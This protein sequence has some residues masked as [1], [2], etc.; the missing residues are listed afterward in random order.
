MKQENSTPPPLQILLLQ[1]Q[2]ELRD[3]I[4]FCIESAYGAVVQEASSYAQ[5]IQFLK[6]AAIPFDIVVLDRKEE[7]IELQNQFWELVG[8]LPVLLAQKVT[9][10][11][12][13]TPNRVIRL[14]DRKKIVESLTRAIDELVNKGMVRSVIVVSDYCRIR[15]RLLLSIGSLRG[16][17]YLRLS[18]DKF[19]KLFSSGANF[20]KDDYEKY[21]V[22]KGIP[23]LYI[24]KEQCQEFTEQY[25]AQ[26]GKLLTA[27]S[28]NLHKISSLNKFT[29]EIVQELIQQ[30][31]FTKAV[32]N[33][34]RTQ[35]LLTVKALGGHPKLSQIMKEIHRG[36]GKYI[37]SHST[38]CAYFACSLA[39]ELHWTT[40]S[41]FQKLTLASFLHDITLS[42]HALAA[43]DSLSELDAKKDQFTEQ[44]QQ[45]YRDH[46]IRSAELV[47]N[48]PEIPPDV[49][50]IILQHHEK[51]DGTGFPK[52]IA[53][54]YIAPLA[55][56]FIVAHDLTRFGINLG[57]D[58]DI[59]D[60]LLEARDRYQSSHFRK[61]L[62]CLEVL[63]EKKTENKVKKDDIKP[64]Q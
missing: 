64:K 13:L 20:D 53:H 43:I 54:S 16:D 49:D 35:V 61:I 3:R 59:D 7:S 58:F 32:Q 21:T 25:D 2:P 60:F 48:M 33:L 10:E 12:F 9:A 6:E 50:T 63:R 22:Q 26:L 45:A 56:V 5:A 28:I 51:P 52:K 34:V 42:N 8:G 55:S 36:E 30:I 23:Y 37:P 4:V 18:Q 1:G 19:V 27:D 14:L 11:K 31:G 17:L 15:A 57:R 40:E 24:R 46:P 44:E 29:T 47:R 38:I 39:A 41:T 62:T